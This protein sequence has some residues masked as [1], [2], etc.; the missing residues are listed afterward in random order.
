MTRWLLREGRRA[1]TIEPVLV[2]AVEQLRAVEVPID[3]LWAGTF[4]LHPQ[5]AAYVWVWS[6]EHPRALDQREISY[7]LFAKLESRDSPLRRLRFGGAP[8]LRVRLRELEAPHELRDIEALRERDFTDFYAHS[9]LFREEFVGGFT[10]STQAPRGF[11]DEEIE[12]LEEV[13]PAL[14]A[15]IEPLA[16]DLAT[17]SLL[18]AYLGPN[19]SAQVLSGQVRRG[20]GQTIRA[21]IWFCDI[22]GFTRLTGSLEQPALLSLLND[23]FEVIV[24]QLAAR[25]GEVLKFMGDGVLAIFA[26][27]DQVARDHEGSARRA[28]A[29]A[30]QATEQVL[31][32][33]A[34]VHERR[35]AA[36]LPVAPIGVGLHYGDVMYGN[37]GAPARLDFTVIGMAVN[38]AARIEG[39]CARLG[40]DVLA[41]E[42]FASRCGGPSTRVDSVALK[43]VA[44]PVELHALEFPTRAAVA[45]AT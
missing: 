43:G 17:A 36:G 33:L 5:A 13:L 1:R 10:W 23:T 28:C 15:V 22:R 11:T 14:S 30:Y 37:I 3:R 16:R 7:T 31:L 41:S 6:R 29:A 32:G 20:D 44:E 12:V 39:Q 2:G 9:L 25:G 19:A 26:E 21:A 4:L 24:E 38:V 35:R 27:D 18:R 45:P 42:R 8:A 40:R 34:A